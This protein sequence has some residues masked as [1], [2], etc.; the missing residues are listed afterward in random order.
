MARQRETNPYFALHHGRRVMVSDIQREAPQTMAAVTA[1]YGSGEIQGQY[2]LPNPETGETDLQIWMPERVKEREQAVEVKI[3]KVRAELAAIARGV[4]FDQS[5]YD[6]R[7]PAPETIR[8]P[9]VEPNLN[10][11]GAVEMQ[12]G[13]WY[14]LPVA[15]H[16]VR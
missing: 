16:N 2:T 11:N 13:Q 15:K 1:F 9:F 10:S 4:D 6:P 5:I 14:K 12:E 7:I 3:A 8:V